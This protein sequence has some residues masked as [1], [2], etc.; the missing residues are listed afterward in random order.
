MA[1]VI[2]LAEYRKAKEIATWREG[3]EISYVDIGNWPFVTDE[4]W[5]DAGYEIEFTA[6]FDLEED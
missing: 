3:M 4:D 5:N 2:I 6:D 1:K